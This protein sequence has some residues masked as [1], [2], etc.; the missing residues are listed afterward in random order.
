MKLHKTC[1]IE[2][3]YVKISV[4]CAK[5]LD[6]SLDEHSLFLSHVKAVL[7]LLSKMIKCKLLYVAVKIQLCQFKFKKGVMLA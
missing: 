4:S 7:V 3:F 2:F 1:C 5:L 6:I